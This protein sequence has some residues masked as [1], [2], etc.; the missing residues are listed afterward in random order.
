VTEPTPEADNW[1]DFYKNPAPPPPPQPKPFNVKRLVG[2]CLA[3]PLVALL[4]G[5]LVW[6]RTSGEPAPTAKQQPAAQVPVELEK[7]LPPSPTPP[8][9]KITVVA[10]DKLSGRSKST[11]PELTKVATDEG[12]RMQA[13]PQVSSV[14]AAVYGSHAKKNVILVLAAA[15]KASASDADT[16]VNNA[17]TG[18]DVVT[19]PAMFDA[20]PLGG[21]AV[22]GEAK[23]KGVSYAICGWADEGSLGIIICYYTSMAKLQAEFYALRA[24]VEKIS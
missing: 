21:R 6:G 7:L 15:A 5:W 24:E 19:Q 8:A 17:I 14:A 3:I 1:Q 20:G 23:S 22:C 16:F 9:R 2:I 10:P 4:V 13:L 12:T 18:S 11:D